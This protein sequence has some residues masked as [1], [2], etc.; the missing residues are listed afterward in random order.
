MQKPFKFSTSCEVFKKINR[1]VN[2]TQKKTTHHQLHN[3]L[4]PVIYNNQWWASQERLM[5]YESKG[6]VT[7]CIK[8]L[9]TWAHFSALAH[10]SCE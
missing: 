6:S 2:K 4:S 1:P 5:K 10:H 7:L 8:R 9:Y 3:I